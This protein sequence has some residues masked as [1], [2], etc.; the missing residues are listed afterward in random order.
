MFVGGTGK[1]A[2]AFDTVDQLREV[3]GLLEYQLATVTL[4][5]QLIDRGNRVAIGVE[6]GL[7]SL[8]ECSLVLAPYNAGDDG[9][10][11]IGVLGPTRMDYR[12]AMSA[13]AVVGQQ[14]TVVLSDI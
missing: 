11:T 2:D 14:L 7:P 13:V 12:Q 8:S 5:C 6:T 10:G 1:L 9:S 4:I 3:L